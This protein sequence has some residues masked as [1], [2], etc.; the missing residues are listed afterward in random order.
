MA[1]E[2]GKARHAKD[3][4][5]ELV[6]VYCQDLNGVQSGVLDIRIKD[7][8]IQLKLVSGEGRI[9][10]HSLEPGDTFFVPERRQ[11]RKSEPIVETKRPLRT[12][13]PVQFPYDVE[14]HVA[15]GQDFKV[16][17]LSR[18]KQF[19]R[20]SA[21]VSG[22]SEVVDFIMQPGDAVVI[23]AK[24]QPRLGDVIRARIAA[25]SPP[26]EQ[27]NY[28]TGMQPGYEI[29][30]YNL[31]PPTSTASA[32]GLDRTELRRRTMWFGIMVLPVLICSWIVLKSYCHYNPDLFSRSRY[33]S[34]A[35]YSD[36]MERMTRLEDFGPN[37]DKVQEIGPAEQ[38]EPGHTGS[39]LS[40]VTPAPD[41]RRVDT[42][43]LLPP[44]RTQPTH[45]DDTRV[46]EPDINTSQSSATSETTPQVPAHGQSDPKPQPTPDP[47]RFDLESSLP[48]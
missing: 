43:G 5:E 33:S 13:A 7:G 48:L 1:I 6:L 10:W 12:A 16:T 23:L 27:Q 34:T 38:R 19:I 47:R 31:P 41:P 18:T 8:G 26:A 21:L 9:A 29:W 3:P 30:K 35:K 37:Y 4:N 28:R 44:M 39:S 45:Q 32:I 15:M 22:T 40:A 24:V 14:F 46:K 11:T 2:T 20:V 25:S 36:E 17:G 42:E